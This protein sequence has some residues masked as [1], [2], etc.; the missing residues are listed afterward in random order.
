MFRR[1]WWMR[2][3]AAGVLALAGVALVR[4]GGVGGA[5]RAETLARGA[6]RQLGFVA[7]GDA[8][9]VLDGDRALAWALERSRPGPAGVDLAAREGGALRWR[10]TFSGGGEAVVSSGGAL[11]AVRRPAPTD[12]GIDLFPAAARE[13]FERA[14]AAFARTPAAWRFE[15]SQTWREAGHTW[16]RARYLET[17]STMPSGW[18]REVEMEVSGSTLIAVRFRV[19]PL[20][21]DLGVVMGRI[22]ELRALRLVGLVGAAIVAV[23][24]LLAGIEAI[25]YHE[26]LRLVRGA[27]VGALAAACGSLAGESPQVIA[28]QGLLTAA[29]VA[30]LPT[31]A[32]LPRSRAVRGAPVGIV[33][34]A[35]ALL[36]PYLVNGTGAWMP[37]SPAVPDDVSPL[38]LLG[39]SWFP[40]LAE[41][42]LLRGAF[43]GLL[44]PIVGWWGGALAGACLGAL[45][46]PLPSVPLVAA[47]GV[48]LFIQ[49]GMVVA[50]RV[51]GVGGAVLAR[52]VLGGIVL[53]QAYPDG[54]WWDAAA[55]SAVAV[56]VVL[57]AFRRGTE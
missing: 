18:R 50:A 42:P 54:A 28:I 48:E 52:A 24:M 35:G 41:E 16:H 45:L 17:A 27:A 26:A 31:W 44:G 2:W 21:T 43:P 33:L 12:P 29:A 9:V 3:L 40:A 32:F 49:A 15:R 30:L 36:A 5:S 56:G 55:L 57:L 25:A 13:V 20:G 11:A 19:Y 51:A 6:L 4:R 7:T 14:L 47:L 34:A 37:I 53:R 46:H 38:G 23:A 22:A 1:R 39:A 10:V 8:S